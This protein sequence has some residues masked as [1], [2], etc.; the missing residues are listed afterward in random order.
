ML[1]L[2]KT[3]ISA[4]LPLEATFNHETGSGDPSCTCRLHFSKIGQSMAQLLLFNH[5]RYL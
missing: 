5:F 4:A 2:Q 3:T 1:Q